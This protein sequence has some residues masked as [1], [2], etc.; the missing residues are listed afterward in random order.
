MFCERIFLMNFSEVALRAA[1]TYKKR[2]QHPPTVLIVPE[3]SHNPIRQMVPFPE[4][5]SEREAALLAAGTQ[6]ARDFPQFR[7]IRQ[8]WLI[9]EAWVS[10]FDP[11]ATTPLIAPSRD[12]K[13]QEVLLIGT[14]DGN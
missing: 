7:S 13:R 2:R 12:P 4:T 9:T 10:S 5:A 14:L 11:Q 8:L 3:G 6:F 1:A